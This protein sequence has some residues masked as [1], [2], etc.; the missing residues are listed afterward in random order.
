VAWLAR[1]MAG[2]I[3]AV[4]VAPIVGATDV[5]RARW[6]SK[7]YSAMPPPR[8]CSPPDGS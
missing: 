8:A 1:T 5:R 7:V 6:I 2:L 4:G 3:A